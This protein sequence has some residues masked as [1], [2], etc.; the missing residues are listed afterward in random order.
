MCRSSVLGIFRAQFRMQLYRAG[1]LKY[2]KGHNLFP[3]E[4]K[5][6]LDI[7][8]IREGLVVYGVAP[9]ENGLPETEC[10][11]DPFFE[12]THDEGS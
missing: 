2:D 1:C 5:F 4:D 8:Q 12:G 11:D 3:V 7:E 9:W 10:D 6:H